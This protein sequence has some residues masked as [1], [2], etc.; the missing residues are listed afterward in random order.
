MLVLLR[1]EYDVD[2]CVNVQG[3]VHRMMNTVRY[4]TVA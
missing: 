3:K 4:E 1:W 2:R